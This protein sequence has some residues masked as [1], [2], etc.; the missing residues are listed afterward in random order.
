LTN[1]FEPEKVH[2]ALEI[3]KSGVFSPHDP[4]RIKGIF[5]NVTSRHPHIKC[6]YLTIEEVHTTVQPGALKFYCIS[7]EAL[8]PHGFF[9]LK[10]LRGKKQPILGEWEQFI[11][12][13]T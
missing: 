4:Q 2:V 6:V 5:D 1:S 7:K 12:F 10:D 13:A 9:A 11:E 3:K 8:A